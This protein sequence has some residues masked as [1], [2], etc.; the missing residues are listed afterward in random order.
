MQHQGLQRIFT[1]VA[2]LWVGGFVTV[3]Y[4]VTPIL[5]STLGDRQVA[6]IVAGNIFRVEAY[7]S[8]ALSLVLMVTANFL[9]SKGENAYRLIRWLLLAMLACAISAG[10]V[11]IPWMSSL[12]DQANADSISVMASS[13]AALF[14]RLHGVSSSLFVI[15][16]VLGIALLWRLTKK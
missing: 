10:L 1:I 5:F 9:V 2:G 12:R 3:A 4:L 14:S 15:Q 6:G 16:S 13:S 8:I 7:F 11:L